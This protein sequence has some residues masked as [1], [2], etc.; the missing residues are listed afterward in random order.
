VFVARVSGDEVLHTTKM[1]ISDDSG[2][3]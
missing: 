2:S 3:T 1:S